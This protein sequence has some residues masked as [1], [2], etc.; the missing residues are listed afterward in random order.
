MQLRSAA[1]KVF[2]LYYRLIDLC[3]PYPIPV[4]YVRALIE[5]EEYDKARELLLLKLKSRDDV[6]EPNAIDYTLH[7]LS[8]TW[9]LA[10]KY[11]EAISFFSEYIRRY[12]GDVAAYVGR[13]TALWYS[14]Q[15]EQAIDDFSRALE[16]KPDDILSLSSRGQVLAEIG[17]NKR[18]L[19]D[20]NTALE[21]LKIAPRPNWS[22]GKWYEEIEGFVRRGRGVALAG[23]GEHALA[24]AEFDLSITLSPE[25]AWVY[26][27]RACMH[28]IAGS[29][30]KA[31]SDYQKALAKNNPRL[32]PV[33][34][35]RAEERLCEILGP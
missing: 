26:Y 5:A 1:Q 15:V 9:S 11:Q 34:Q 3:I 24:M 16:L 22:W 7:S 19:E 32:N 33:R 23:L 29:P 13:A 2:Q 6:K 4:Y 17:Q 14:G 20:L 18:A 21:L 28:D 30:E 35:K 25:N 8:L 10:D 12:P 27:D 31:S